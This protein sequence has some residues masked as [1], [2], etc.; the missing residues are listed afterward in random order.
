MSYNTLQRPTDGRIRSVRARTH[1]NVSMGHVEYTT[2]S[3]D[4]MIM[5]MV[6]IVIIVV[7]V[8]LYCSSR[9]TSEIGPYTTFNL[10]HG[11]NLSEIFV[12]AKI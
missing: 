8:V 7:V 2:S 10:E 1:K 4:G 6:I 11:R 12:G 9:L 5:M 3:L